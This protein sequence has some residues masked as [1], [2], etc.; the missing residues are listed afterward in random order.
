MRGDDHQVRAFHNICRHRG[1][2]LV[3]GA[4]G[5][6]PRALTCPFHGWT[7]RLDGALTGVPAETTFTHLDKA[8]NG[9]AP[10]AMEIW[11]GFVFVRFG[12]SADSADSADKPSLAETMK[13]VEQLASLYQMH[14]MQPIDGT[15]FEEVRPCNWKVIHDIDNE[16]YHVAHGHPALQQLYGKNYRDDAIGGVP[17]TY[18]YLN[19]EPG[20][21]W[22]VRHYQKLLPAFDHLPAGHQRLWV[23]I[24]LFPSMVLALYPDGMDYYMTIPVNAA[25]TRLKGGSYALP[26]PRRETRAA[27]YLGARINRVSSREDD[28]FVRRLYCGMQSSAFPEPRLSSIE[29]GVRAFHRQIQQVLP[30][31][32]LANEPQAGTLAGVNG[33]MGGAGRGVGGAGRARDAHL[34]WR[35]ARGGWRVTRICGGRPPADPPCGAGKHPVSSA[36]ARAKRGVGCA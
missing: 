34:R 29:H 28:E 20:A 33:E 35:E 27:R 5:R 8:E 23:Y 10:L 1:A 19:E 21:L 16:G 30:V 7:Y 31:A 18:G 36:A 32:T 15:R 14:K 6:C 9:L 25:S 17:V 13:P 12:G 2:K 11:M 24:G 3:E 4:R 22:S 26:D